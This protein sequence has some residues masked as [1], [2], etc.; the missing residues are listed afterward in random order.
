MTNSGSLRRWF[1][2]GGL[3]LLGLLG[4]QYFT[5]PSNGLAGPHDSRPILGTQAVVVLIVDVGCGWS[6]D[7][8]L[9]QVWE[10]LVA[11]ISSTLPDSVSGVY[12]VGVAI[13]PTQSEG[14]ALL[15]RIGSFEEVVVGGRA[16]VGLMRYALADFEGI[17]STPQVILTYRTLLREDDGSI[18]R[19]GEVLVQRIRGLVPIGEMADR[20]ASAVP[21]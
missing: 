17:A 15:E 4:T 13:S 1:T 14:L 7:A 20:L 10:K 3:F 8:T 5:S 2:Y 12:T 21:Q 6:N 9:P 16:N 19:E 11:G 18:I